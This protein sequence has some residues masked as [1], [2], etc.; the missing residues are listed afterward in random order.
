MASY[1]CDVV[2]F[3]SFFAFV[4]CTGKVMTEHKKATHATNTEC[5]IN[6]HFK[7]NN[8]IFED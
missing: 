8:V 3:F 7:M 2:H 1:F 5:T 6:K 4:H